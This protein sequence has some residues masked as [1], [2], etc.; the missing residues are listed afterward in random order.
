MVRYAFPEEGPNSTFNLEF[1]YIQRHDRYVDRLKIGTLIRMT[2]TPSISCSKLK[3][4]L[5]ALRILVVF[6]VKLPFR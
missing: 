2:K 3:L 1:C 5:V 6:E 4:L